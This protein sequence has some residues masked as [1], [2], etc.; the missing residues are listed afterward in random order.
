[1]TIKEIELQ[2]G[3][4]RANIRF[5]EAEGLI[6]PARHDNGYR[7]YSEDDLETLKRIK[8][9]RA[10]D[11][12]LDEIKRLHSGEESLDKALC[13]HIELLE[14]RRSE[15]SRSQTICRTMR[16]DGVQYSTLNAQ[17]YLDAMQRAYPTPVTVPKEDAIP[18]V[19]AP[20]RRYFARSIDMGIYSLIWAAF[21]AVAFHINMLDRNILE[22]LLDAVVTM[23][24]LLLI[25]PLLLNRFGTTPGKWLLGLSV[26]DSDGRKLSYLDGFVRT[27][28]V[29]M[30]GYGLQIPVF[31]L[32]RLWKSYKAVK[33]DDTLSWE[34]ETVLQLRDEKLWRG[35]VYVLA[36]AAIMGLL[37]V[38][39]FISR[40]PINLGDLTIAEFC[41]NYNHYIEYYDFSTRGTLDE[42]GHLVE[43]SR[44]Y[45]SGVPEP[46]IVSPEPYFDFTVENGYVTAISFTP[47]PIASESLFAS[48]THREEVMLAAFSFVG[49][50]Y[51]HRIFSDELAKRL[52]EYADDPL[53]D[54]TL[55]MSG[56]EIRYDVEA[57]GC[58]Y[59]DGGF[60]IAENDGVPYT[61][62]FTFTMKKVS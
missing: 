32:Y 40:Q 1:L 42:R 15:V 36:E 29:I 46:D 44:V 30:D 41:E 45:N 19:K 10:L 4:P 16:S 21:L 48:G 24:M 38:A 7:D 51:E 5:Y 6:S 47:D 37:L 9:L 58:R 33:A 34:G 49:A 22:K 50:Q 43:P 12:G 26:V 57:S 13:D 62:S 56:V 14:K 25:E 18:K 39:V 59:V 52:E 8:L 61:F 60:L 23:L 31:S 35:A 17:T 3:I 54:F 28:N 20:W 2:S 27:A 53:A 11:M 55:T